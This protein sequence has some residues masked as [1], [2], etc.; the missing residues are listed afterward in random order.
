VSKATAVH[1]GWSFQLATVAGIPI[2]IH[3]TFVL[4][5]VWFGWIS[6]QQGGDLFLSLVALLLLFAC[7]VL[8]ELGHAL[9]AQRFGVQTQ[10]IVLYPIGGIA[11]L[12]SMPSGKAEL[13]IAIAGPLVNVVIV[14]L[15]LPLVAWIGPAT[16]NRLPLIVN[17]PQIVGFLILSNGALFLFNLIP[18]FPMDGGRVLRAALTLQMPEDRATNIA[19]GIGQ[20]IAVLFAVVGLFWNPFLLL[21]ALFVFMGAGQ[22]AAF[23]Q[24]RFMVRGRFA[25]EAMITRFET[26]APQDDLRH[27]TQLLLDSHQHDFP[28]VDA[29]GRI[30]G[31][32]SRS[33]MLASLAERGPAAAVL[34][35][36]DREVSTVE[37]G[38]AMDEVLRRLQTD[39]G[40]PVLVV[41]DGRLVGMITLENLAEFIE[42]ARRSE[43][44]APKH[45]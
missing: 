45:A 26:L 18:A 17:P 25:R 7:V 2:R 28:V 13:V 3:F 35:I 10:E 41:Q 9:T 31:V 16:V 27:A 29:W 20:A 22:E 32:L 39:P 14:A 1:T 44:A 36:M 23:V 21:I 15:L 6:T 37:Q 11:R 30:A 43:A 38:A 5:L 40:K 33:A 4:I 42:I 19:A 24:R 12:K 8:H 34:E